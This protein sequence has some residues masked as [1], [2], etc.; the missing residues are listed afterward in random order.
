TLLTRCKEAIK[1]H[2]EKQVDLVTER[3]DLIQKLNEKQQFIESMMKD[4]NSEET[5]AASLEVKE[6]FNSDITVLLHDKERLQEELESTRLCIRQLE[7]DLELAR[8]QQ[9]IKTDFNDEI[10]H[11]QDEFKQK[12]EDLLTKFD[13]KTIELEKLIN[14]KL[15]LETSNKEFQNLM[16]NYQEEILKD[17]Q[18]IE[19]LNN[20][21]E[22]LK[23]NLSKENEQHLKSF[24]TLKTEYENLTNELHQTKQAK[25]N[26]QSLLD[27][28]TQERTIYKDKYQSIQQLEHTG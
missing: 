28:T 12:Y 9:N 7:I 10:K 21:I 6:H 26:I 27:E 15:N 18:Q 2:Q 22:I 8:K 16:K 17:K 11:Q 3:D 20:E 13:E 24:D 5:S 19:Q 25:D 4:R 14:D 1:A 23:D